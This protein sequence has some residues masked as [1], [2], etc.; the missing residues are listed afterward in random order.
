M[1][2]FPPHCSHR[3]QP[4]DVSFMKPLSL[5]YDEE[6]RKWLRTNPGKVVTLFEISKLFAQ[7]FLSSANM[8]T[9]LN[10][11]EK[12]GIW[13]VNPNIF[14]D[15]DFLPSM[16]T[17]IQLETSPAAHPDDI[18]S[19]SNNNTR[20]DNLQDILEEI[21]VISEKVTE[22]LQDITKVNKNDQ[23][24]SGCSW[25]TNSPARGTEKHSSSFICVSPKDVIPLPKVQSGQKRATRKRG[26]S[27]V[28]TSSPYKAELEVAVEKIE[29]AKKKQNWRGS[30]ERN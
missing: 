1:I 11:F 5:H 29:K 2:C 12:T 19:K 22:P 24:T 13:P 4:L 26:K 7:A 3:L 27:V 28:L 17:D 18:R 15:I 9:A 16:T 20:G 23:N 25:M 21:S 6:T 30:K 10:G 8:K 14:T